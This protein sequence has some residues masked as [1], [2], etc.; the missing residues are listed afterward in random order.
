MVE[1]QQGLGLEEGWFRNPLGCFSDKCREVKRFNRSRESCHGGGTV[2]H[3][4]CELLITVL[5][6]ETMLACDGACG[7]QH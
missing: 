5:Y 6:C 4:H 7:V 3:E 2:L 1:T